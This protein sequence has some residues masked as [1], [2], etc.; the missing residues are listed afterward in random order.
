MKT[1]K[2]CLSQK[3]Y[4]VWIDEVF[5]LA[6]VFFIEEGKEKI[7]GLG[8]ITDMPVRESTLSVGLLVRE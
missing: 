5:G 7:I 3:I 6:K 2:Y 8:M 1:L 4:V